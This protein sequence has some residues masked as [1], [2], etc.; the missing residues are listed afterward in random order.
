MITPF[1]EK[2]IVDRYRA[3]AT[4]SEAAERYRAGERNGEGILRIGYDW[5]GDDLQTSSEVEV[6][7]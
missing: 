4:L 7:I 1:K 2:L 5:S 6:V 3:K